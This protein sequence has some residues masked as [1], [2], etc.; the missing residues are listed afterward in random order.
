M[1]KIDAK[2]IAHWAD[3]PDA[4]NQLPDLIRRLI[5]AT[6]P[7][8]TRCEMP[9]G[10]A[11]DLPGWD[12]IVDSANGTAYVSAGRSGWEFGTA[13]RP[14][15]KADGDFDKRTQEPLGLDP[16]T[17]A[18]TFV[19]PRLWPEGHEWSREREQQGPWAVVRVLNAS[20]LSAW[21]DEAPAVA[22]WFAPK[23]GLPPSGWLDL[24]AWW[25]NWT[26]ELQE[27]TPDLLMAGREKEVAQVREWCSS[28][29]GRLVIEADTREEALAFFAASVQSAEP[30]LRD[31]IL[32]RALVIRESAAATVL[33]A[34]PKGLLIIDDVPASE[35]P[36][37]WTV[38]NR[39]FIPCG[40]GERK[41]PNVTLPRLGPEEAI[42]ALQKSGY[43]YS[44]ARRL[45]HRAG[46]RLDLLR[47]LVDTAGTHRP[48]WAT[49][50]ASRNLPAL[51]LLG[52]WD[53][54]YEE[55]RQLVC[56]LCQT[57]YDNI[58]NEITRVMSN[59]ASPI[60]RVGEQYRFVSPEVAWRWLE[61]Q[62]TQT[63]TNRF[64]QASIEALQATR[65]TDQTMALA[66]GQ[67]SPGFSPTLIEGVTT[68]LAMMG[69]LAATGE[70]NQQW[71]AVPR[72]TVGR[73][74][75]EPMTLATWRG[76]ARYLSSLAEAAPD[77]FLDWIERTLRKWPEQ[78]SALLNEPSEIHL[79]GWEHI[80]LTGAL[81]NL[82][83]HAEYFPRVIAA[84]AQLALLDKGRDLAPGPLDALKNLMLP[85]FRFTDASDNVRINVLKQTFARYPDL[86]P[87]IFPLL[88][89]TEPDLH[90]L[91]DPPYWRVCDVAGYVQ[92]AHDERHRYRTGLAAMMLEAID[93]DA[94]A[95]IKAI[96]HLGSYPRDIVSQIVATLSERA[97][98]IANHDAAPRLRDALHR[99]LSRHLTYHD[100][101]RALPA[102]L[103]DDLDRVAQQLEPADLVLARVSI[104]SDSPPLPLAKPRDPEER[105][106]QIENAQDSA[107][108]ELYEAS[109]I[110]ALCRAAECAA[111]PDRIGRAA[112]RVLP[113][114]E[115]VS[116]ARDNL[117]DSEPHLNNLARGTLHVLHR[118]DGDAWMSL[119]DQI[120]QNHGGGPAL[121]TMYLVLDPDTDLF[122]LL[123]RERPDTQT[124][125]WEGFQRYH[126]GR[127]PSEDQ[128]TAIRELLRHRRADLAG[129]YFAFRKTSTDILRDILERLPY[130]LE[131]RALAGRPTMIA[132]YHIT[133]LFKQLD[134][135]DDIST[136]EIDQLEKPLLFLLDDDSR[137]ERERQLAAQLRI[138]RDPQ[139]F[140]RYVDAMIRQQNEG[141]YRTAE[142]HLL[143]TL[144]LPELI[145]DSDQ[146]ENL[147]LLTYAN[148]A[149]VVCESK[150]VREEGAR[151]L[152]EA[153][154]RAPDGADGIWPSEA[155]RRA[156]EAI[157]DQEF[158]DGVMRGRFNSR[159][160]T[161]RGVFGGGEQERN[162]EAEYRLHAD[163]VQARYPRTAEILRRLARN[164]AH[165]ARHEDEQ[166]EWDDLTYR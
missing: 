117:G 11:T 45:L 112:A 49:P 143:E 7:S 123:R 26:G 156:I 148:E 40:T 121:A 4:R 41:S 51:S 94:E 75:E 116:L 107:V 157:P 108:L 17:T 24:E 76:I 147:R 160:V 142:Y 115:V 161:T 70:V 28:D 33:Q 80:Y 1:I 155:A 73:L 124:A 136:D 145:Q 111:V 137:R 96:N 36:V 127:V 9:S 95:W 113:I 37:I 8:V 69:G 89:S 22:A 15:S 99:C 67:K 129:G 114:D 12:G 130:D 131:D 3:T 25:Q 92:P 56:K 71:E 13:N 97:S 23:V 81:E 133:E 39:T 55:D 110:S 64:A 125:Y 126:L 164:Y 78:F 66:E 85:D 31:S 63:A 150:S 79:D 140:A 50:T 84:L 104:F 163:A 106:K 19:T 98:K 82:A 100:A 18:F 2:D 128:P 35:Q 103:L 132:A 61:T 139:R 65:S 10:S 27:L 58:E 86:G 165:L 57:D 162:I 34:V 72:K 90:I 135:A 30:V 44:G 119:M 42:S 153:V 47:F 149:L 53:A 38:G 20:D 151:I 154:G 74:V 43:G 52:Q 77:S 146:P 122:D 158:A 166:A 5:L 120:R 109:G 152:G 93:E 14:K 105:D 102:S 101:N 60:R 21:L 141:M 88:L 59:P 159:G 83:W 46:R 54:R 6:D 91:P 138:G 62:I 29:N 48:D 16:S 87:L 144:T 118:R 32:S 134:D 68:T